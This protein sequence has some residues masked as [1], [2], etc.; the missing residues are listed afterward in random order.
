[1]GEPAHISAQWSSLPPRIEGG[2][3]SKL[4]EEPSFFPRQ[5]RWHPDLSL[6]IEVPWF[7]SAVRQPTPLQAQPAAARSACGYVHR[8]G[9][10]RSIDRDGCAQRS[11]PR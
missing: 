8:G 10:S 3:L 9:T 2:A 11:L 6:G 1:M 4:L 5:R 7:A